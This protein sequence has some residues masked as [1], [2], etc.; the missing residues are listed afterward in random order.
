MKSNHA[1]LFEHITE[2]SP[3]STLF[4]AFDQDF[5]CGFAAVI[6]SAVSTQPPPM[7]W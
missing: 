5:Y 6:F 4:E 1:N 7:A 3:K 2:S